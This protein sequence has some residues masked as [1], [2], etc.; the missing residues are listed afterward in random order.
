MYG[1]VRVVS[2]ENGWP[3]NSVMDII[4]TAMSF[5]L[6]LLLQKYGTLSGVTILREDYLCQYLGL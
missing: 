5:V 4:S 2:G 6:R 1:N 3:L